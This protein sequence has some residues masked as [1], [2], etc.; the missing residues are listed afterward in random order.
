[1]Q[2]ILITAYKD[3]KELLELV[4][5]LSPHFHLYIHLDKKWNLTESD[6]DQI[7]LQEN[8]KVIQSYKVNWGSFEHL[9]AIL[10]LCRLGLLERN[11]HRFHIISGQDYP[12]ID[13]EKLY[14]FFEQEQTKEFILST[15]VNENAKMGF[16][17]RVLS[18]IKYYYWYNRIDRSKWINKI[19]YRISTKF[20][21]VIGVNKLKRYHLDFDLYQGLVWSSLTRQAVEKSIRYADE[22]CN[23]IKF[24]KTC[25]APEEF[26]FQTVLEND[27]SLAPNIERNNLRYALYERRNGSCPAVLNEY[28]Y[29]DIK[30]SGAFWA[31]KIVSGE[32][33]ALKKLLL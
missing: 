1:M 31:R 19:F 28:D 17:K 6:L 5:L 4:G 11:N 14:N 2:A 12:A 18:W 30:K 24:L 21:E 32:S 20:Q 33:D 10:D 13:I 3:F 26:F 25:N 15:K 8:V 22:E 7:R 27:K 23:F 29:A 16:E 9:Q